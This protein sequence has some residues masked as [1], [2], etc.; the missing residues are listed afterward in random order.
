VAIGAGEEP[1]G[2]V[3]VES[4]PGQAE[5]LLK[6][7]EQWPDR[8]WAVEGAAGLGR[9]L[10]R[11]LVAAG[12][13]VL[14]VQPKLAAR[15]RLLQAGDTGKNDP[16][17]AQSVAVAALRSRA[18]RA[19]TAEDH[20]V[21]L[22]I[23]A[24]RHRD[25]ARARNQVACRLHAVLCELVPGGVRKQIT[26]GHAAS[27]VEQV[28]ARDAVEAARRE[29]AAHFLEDLRRLDGQMREA[30][31]KLAAA[32][33]ASGTTVTDVLGVGPVN[34]GTI[35][36]DVADMNRFPT[37]DHF[38]AYN[39]T[40][41][42]EVS[43]GGRKVYRL[44]LRGNRR[45]NH[46]IHMAAITQIRHSHSDGRAYYEK[47]IAEGKTHKEAVRCLKRRIS[48][49]IYARLRADAKMTVRLAGESPGGQAGHG[50]D[51]SAASS[52]PEHR[53]FG[54]AT[55]GPA[56]T[57]RPRKPARVPAARNRHLKDLERTR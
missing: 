16:H 22:K 34:A 18:C 5:D 40:A 13:L 11:Q 37:R 35:I 49:A 25:L 36:G 57:L 27:V 48:D 45:I 23:W 39:A 3:W 33:R 8:T 15:V 9:L 38:A 19:V 52:H 12:E 54:Q 14:D 32:V 10:A 46:A 17:D 24:R 53:L 30:N 2:K 42:T 43:S 1:L 4:S 47:K 28:T 26:A 21:V 55:P 29:L 41:P 6:W 31:K 51:S 50:S 20:T 44:S 56:T 7:A